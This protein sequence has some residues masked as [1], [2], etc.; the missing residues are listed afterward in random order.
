[1]SRF[2]R[3]IHAFLISFTCS[4]LSWMII[5]L[6]IINIEFYKY[7]LIELLLLVMLKLSLYIQ[8]KLGI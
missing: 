5:N 3:M 7:I 1:M 4:I 2:E 8:K 6:L